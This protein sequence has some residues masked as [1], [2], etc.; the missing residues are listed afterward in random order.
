[1]SLRVAFIGCGQIAGSHYDGLRSLRGVPGAPELVL[2]GVCDPFSGRAESWARETLKDGETPALLTDYRQFLDGPHRP[3]LASVLVP[4]HLHLEITES[5]LRAGIAVQLQKPIGLGIRDSRR[6]IEIA[7]E[8]GTP[9][10]VSEPSI[11]GRD[12]RRTLDWLQS[13]RDIGRPLF[14]VDQAVID[15]Q[16]GFFMTPWRHLKGY[17]GAGWFIDH[18][19]HRTHWMLEA[20][21]PCRSAYARTRI[22]EPL[23]RDERWGEVP[24]D[25]ED[26]AAAV[27]EFE[28]GLVCQWSVMSGGR[29]QGHW[30]VQVWGERGSFHDDRFTVTGIK[31]THPL[32]TGAETLPANPFSHSFLE[33][34]GLIRDPK[35]PVISTPERALE[36]E[37]IVY[38]A[39]ESAHIGQPVPV[40]AIISGEQHAYED[41]VWAAREKLRAEN[42]DK[43]T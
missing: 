40:S 11:L 33:L 24:V 10:V 23:R 13:G 28:S 20:F 34:I 14:M 38:A 18:G 6:I 21:G 25:T 37:A 43:F 16:G 17:A 12:N 42:L 41:T 29:G 4:H 1:M 8:T 5:L 22:I 3:D 2:S 15:L 7:C 39:L 27:L 36:A 30:H 9:L 32:P 19:V 26:M 35:S 31:E